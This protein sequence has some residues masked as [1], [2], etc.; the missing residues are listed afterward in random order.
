MTKQQFLTRLGNALLSLPQE[1]RAQALN[2][3]REYIEDA[4]EAGRTEEEV[5]ASMDAP[6][7]IAAQLRRESA[8]AVAAAKPT[9]RNTSRALIAAL[10]ILSLPIT[11]PLGIAIIAIAAAI[12]ALLLSL[13][14]AAV[15]VIVAV[16]VMGIMFGL[17]NIWLLGSGAVTGGSVAFMIGSGLIGLALSILAV[18]VL[19]LLVQGICRAMAGFF[20]WIGRKLAQK[21]E[22]GGETV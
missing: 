13:V 7:T 11:L 19:V 3:Y 16:V 6:E 14:I 18:I 1:E 2:Y 21:R 22:K 8:F 5:T 20:R 12:L 9:P 4:V 10:G 17:R 15:A